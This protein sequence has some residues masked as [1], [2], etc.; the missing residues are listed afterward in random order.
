MMLGSAQGSI[1]GEGDNVMLMQKAASTLLRK[2]EEDLPQLKYC[3]KRQFPEMA[4]VT[5]LEL[6]FELIKT[7]EVMGIGEL[8][9]AIMRGLQGNS[10]F[11]DVWMREE[12]DKIQLTAREYGERVCAEQALAALSSRPDLGA[13]LVPSVTLFLL[14]LVKSDLSWYLL[15]GII[16]PVAAK[17]VEEEWSQ[18]VKRFGSVAK[19]LVE[20]F[21][22]PEEL[23][24]APAATDLKGFYAKRTMGSTCR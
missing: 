18:A 5:T 3:P 23:I 7:K 17:G 16:S 4:N 12:S 9:A 13:F 11:F 1:T 21:D 22:I 2:K 24:F 14:D 10:S 8:K 15:R 6:L 19:D 20:A